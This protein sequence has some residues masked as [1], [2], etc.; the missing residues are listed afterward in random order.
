[1]PIL[2]QLNHHVREKYKVTA[3]LPSVRLLLNKNTAEDNFRPFHYRDPVDHVQTRW[4]RVDLVECPD[5]A[6][7]MALLQFGDEPFIELQGVDKGQLA[8]EP[9]QVFARKS[10][11]Y[12]PSASAGRHL[13]RDF[14]RNT[15]KDLA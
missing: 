8:P 10:R 12:I 1:M 3:R 13:V 5:I 14:L 2:R 6:D 15:G 9:P 7:N 11:P 4:S